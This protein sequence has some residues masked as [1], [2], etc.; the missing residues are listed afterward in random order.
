MHSEALTEDLEAAGLDRH[1]ATVYLRLLQKD[2]AQVGELSPHFDSSRSTLYRLLDNLAEE[3]YVSKSLE[4]PTVY[5]ATEPER[6]FDLRFEAI[7]R[8]RERLNHVRDRRLEELQTPTN[9]E[10]REPSDAH[11]TKMEGTERIY[12]TLHDMILEAEASV[13]SASNHEVSTAQ[14]LPAVEEAWRVAVRR[15]ESD[16]LDVRLLLDLDDDPGERVPDWIEPVRTLSIREIDADETI[17]FTMLDGCELLRWVR[18]TPVGTLGKKDDVAV[19][20]NAPG[21]VVAHRML[22]EQRWTRGEPVK[23]SA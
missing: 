21:S 14:F 12:E 10:A 13:W 15:A 22:F 8:E 6:L 3:G 18:P 9:D 11:W 16:G 4:Q 19:K 1:E 7:D 2:R 20:T 17:H 23:L 5:S